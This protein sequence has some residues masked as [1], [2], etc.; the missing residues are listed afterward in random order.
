MAILYE[1]VG[2]LRADLD[3]VKCGT[4]VQ[5]KNPLPFEIGVNFLGYVKACNA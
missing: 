4:P 3:W 1:G 2:V 5:M